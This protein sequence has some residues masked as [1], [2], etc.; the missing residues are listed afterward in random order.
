MRSKK[1]TIDEFKE[2]L[3]LKDPKGKL[4]EQFERISS[5]KKDVL[6]VAK[7]QINEHTNIHFATS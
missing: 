7:K 3:Y 5:L 4:P 2:M 1:F 6:D